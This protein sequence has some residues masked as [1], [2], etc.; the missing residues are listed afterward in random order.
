[1]YIL[2]MAIGDV[3]TKVETLFGWPVW[4]VGMYCLAGLGPVA[5]ACLY[6]V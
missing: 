3:W 2:D 6:M 1:M 4:P 5:A